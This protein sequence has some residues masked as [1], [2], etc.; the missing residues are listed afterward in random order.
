MRCR[1]PVNNS[2]KYFIAFLFKTDLIESIFAVMEGSRLL[3]VQDWV[4]V[5]RNARYQC[6][7]MAVL[8]SVSE[9]QL[10]RFFLAQFQQT[11]KHWL[12][13]LRMGQ[14]LEL[15][16]RGYST[17]ATAHE[18]HFGGPCQF[19]RK[20]KKYFGH[21]AGYYAPQ[22]KMSCLVNDVAFGTSV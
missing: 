21:S 18:L 3:G 14:A 13:S 10:Q 2:P 22:S 5:A 16:K 19:C 17:K 7:Q 9:R 4:R 20:F 12:Q 11:P 8:C 6:N 1:A 15:I